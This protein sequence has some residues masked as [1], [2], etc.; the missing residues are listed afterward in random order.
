[1]GL[2]AVLHHCSGCGEAVLLVW[3]YSSRTSVLEARSPATLHRT[4]PNTLTHRA[5][6]AT[7]WPIS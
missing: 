7:C 5:A 2:I 3:N 4:S 6:D 1:M